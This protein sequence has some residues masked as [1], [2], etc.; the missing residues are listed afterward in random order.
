MTGVQDIEAAVRHDDALSAGACLAD[1]HE[2]FVPGNQASSAL[3]ALVLDRVTDDTGGM[4]MAM[5]MFTASF[6]MGLVTGA[7]AFGFVAE[8]YGYAAMFVAAAMFVGA[9][10]GA[11][12]FLDP[13][14]RKG[15][16][17]EPAP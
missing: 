2:E 9:G 15:E 8:S 6:D 16:R 3:S 13:A 17:P 7:A 4:A 10:T 14:F 1:E 12:F 5:A 11:F